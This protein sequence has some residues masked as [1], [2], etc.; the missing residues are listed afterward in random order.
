MSV[1]ALIRRPVQEVWDFFIDLTNSPQWTASGSEVRQ[2][3]AGAPGVGTTMESVR[4]IFGRELVSQRLKVVAYEPGRLMSMTTAVP[5]LGQV[6]MRFT[7]ESV[8]NGTRLTRAGEV[9]LDGVKGLL[10]QLFAPL[11][12]KGWRIEMRNIKRLIE[13][14]PR[15]VSGSPLGAPTKG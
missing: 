11:L 14:R 2:T 10:G 7:F 6:G 13:A 12:R 3:S 9:E 1:S 15:P 4:S 8:P 5:H